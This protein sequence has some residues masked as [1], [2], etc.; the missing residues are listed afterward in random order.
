MRTLSVSHNNRYMNRQWIDW[1]RGEGTILQHA[2]SD[3]HRV[4][5]P[6]LSPIQP[7][8]QMAESERLELPRA[9]HPN[10]FQDRLTTIIT[11]LQRIHDTFFHTAALPLEL[12]AKSSGPPGRTRTSNVLFPKKND[13]ASVVQKKTRHTMCWIRTNVSGLAS[14]ALTTKLIALNGGQ[15]SGCCRCL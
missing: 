15:I 7:P 13:A 3:V 10:G 2:I 14:G 6:A 4:S 8:L 5:N 9:R 11:T 12:Q 1:R